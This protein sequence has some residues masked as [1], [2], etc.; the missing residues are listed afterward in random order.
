V[1]KEVRWR[2]VSST[3]GIPTP[4]SDRALI[5][6]RFVHN[7]V[8]FVMAA[9]AVTIFGASELIG[10]RVDKRKRIERGG[11]GGGPLIN[12]S[13]RVKRFQRELGDSNLS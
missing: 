5:Q 3:V 10:D 8:R 4:L 9:Y 6:I 11:G 12:E 13:R 2:F 1:R 7:V